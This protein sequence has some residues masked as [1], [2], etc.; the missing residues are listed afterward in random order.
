MHEQLSSVL[1][2]VL[3]VLVLLAPAVAALFFM[4]KPGQI[5][6]IARNTFVESVRQPI[7]FILIFMCGI[8]QL[9]NV[10]G[11][12][13]SMGYTESGEVSGDNK[14]LLDIGLATVFVCGMLLAAFIATAV[15]SRE[16]ENKTVLTVVSKP[17]SRPAVVLGKFLGVAGAMLIATLTMVLFLLMGLR[18][19]VMST[20]AD[21]PDMPVIVFTTLAVVLAL[22]I[23]IWCNFF[24]GWVFTQTTT[25]LLM[26]LMLAA[27]LGVLM[28]GKKWGFQSIAVDFKPQ[29]M[30]ACGALIMAQLVLTAV[31]TAASARLGQVMTIVVCCGI[32]VF[33]LLSNH[34]LGRR[35]YDNAWVAKI[36]TAVPHS[37]NDASWTNA[38]DTY[39]VTLEH[40]P[41]VTLQVGMPFYYGPNPNGF[42]LSTTNFTAPGGDVTKNEVIFNRQAP[43]AL[44]VIWISGRHLMA[45]HVGEDGE[46]ARV[47]PATGDY[48][49]T[50]A[51]RV[52]RV[53]QI[54]WGVIPNVQFFWLVDAISQH[55][56]VPLSHLALILLYAMAQVGVFL[57]LAVL[58]FQKREVG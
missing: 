26:P 31:A 55:Q 41:R 42:P 17:I 35:A 49:F 11:T 18:H 16:I 25:L 19:G 29:V 24:Y 21:D 54:A 10:W 53:A 4:G 52:N 9:F 48:M 13:Y 57:S 45:R 7:Y 47:L 39:D 3:P 37:T 36:Q 43:G 32:F 33:G 14:L 46:I 50:R 22:G 8:M 5:L 1:K 34:F 30:M 12:A 23:G 51:T 6:A 2:G 40:E 58:L 38:G 20:A 56:D 28:V 44:V 27:W 15:I